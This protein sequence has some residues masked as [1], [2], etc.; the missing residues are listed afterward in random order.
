MPMWR[1]RGN[2][3]AEVDRGEGGYVR[4][5]TNKRLLMWGTEAMTS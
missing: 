1:D 5:E 3:L 2:D 4:V